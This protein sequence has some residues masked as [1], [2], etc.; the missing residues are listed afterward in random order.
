MT[1]KFYLYGPPGCGKTSVGQALAESLNLPLFDLDSEIERRAGETIPAVFASHGEEHFRLLERESLAAFMGVEKG[2]VALGGGALLNDESRARVISNGTVI[3]LKASLETLMRRMQAEEGQRP[4]LNGGLE[5]QLVEL[6]SQRADH[7]T[8]FPMQVETDGLQPGEIAWRIQVRLGAFHVKGMGAGYDVRVRADG[9]DSLGEY[10]RRNGLRDGVA[11]VCDENLAQL[12]SSQAVAALERVGYTT[13]MVTIPPGEVHKTV[14]TVTAL[15]DAFVDAGLERGGTVAALGG[16]VTGDL[17]GF[18]AA[19]YLRGVPWAVLP[20]TLLAMVDA[21]L[22]GKTGI[23][24]RRGKNLAGAFH[25]PRLVLADTNT[26]TS[27]PERELRSGMAEVVKAGLIGDPALFERCAQGW[28][29]V[30]ASLDEVVRRAMAVKVQV[31]QADPYE[32]SYRAALNLGH[33]LGH[34]FEMASDYRLLHGEAVA[35]GLAGETR[36][37]ES[38]GLAERGLA[39]KVEETLIRLGLPARLPQELDR[40]TIWRAMQVDKKRVRGSLRFAL[41]ARIGEV[42][43]GIEA[44]DNRVIDQVLDQLS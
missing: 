28:E 14:E 36:L 23:D 18:A 44:P 41:P 38:L 25:P 37:A 34:A 33:T 4:L 31:I 22:G 9:L 12:Y 8:S 10:L 21:S 7:Y 26:L 40:V 13:H 19:T 15:W 11:L 43:V 30:C 3:C 32:N 20:T 1:Y 39:D 35:I 17:A 42:R 16:G 5:T 6:I 29:A 2:V 24:L 27:L